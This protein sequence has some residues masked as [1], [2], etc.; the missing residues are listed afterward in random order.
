[1]YLNDAELRWPKLRT[2]LQFDG[3]G[4]ARDIHI[5]IHIHIYVYINI[6]ILP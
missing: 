5:Y 4:C 6:N 2:Q 1:M 3:F